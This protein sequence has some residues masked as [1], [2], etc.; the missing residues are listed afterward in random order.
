M[1]EPSAR[2]SRWITPTALVEASSE[3]KEF[4][5]TSSA[6]RLVRWAAVAVSGRISCSTTGTPASAACQAAS[7][8]ASPPPMTWMGRMRSDLAEPGRCVNWTG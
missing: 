6:S 8:P 7:D 3:R 5:Q 4:E 2:I 1:I